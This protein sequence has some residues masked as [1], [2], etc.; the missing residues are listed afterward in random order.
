MNLRL[1]D[2]QTLHISV[3]AYYTQRDCDAVV[4]RYR[5]WIT[6]TSAMLRDREDRHT[7][8]LESKH[9]QILYFGEWMSTQQLTEHLRAHG[10][11]DMYAELEAF[12]ERHCALWAE[13]MQVRYT[14]MCLSRAQSFFGICTY[15]NRLR[16]SRMLCFAPKSCIEYVIIHE[17]AHI[18]YKNHSKAFWALVG[19]FCAHHRQSRRFL[20]QHTWLYKALLKQTPYK[21]TPR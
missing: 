6:T 9:G 13:R 3:P 1:K 16:F 7:Q 12:L 18:R 5:E 8:E 21:P 11:A 17:L 15:D 19:E 14:S 2:S 4:E 10:Y 20:R